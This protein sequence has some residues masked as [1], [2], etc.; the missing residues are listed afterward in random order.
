MINSIM[1][2]LIPAIVKIAVGK[3]EFYVASQIFTIDE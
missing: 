2:G 1:A 3:K